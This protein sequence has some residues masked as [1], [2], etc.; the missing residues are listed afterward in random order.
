MSKFRYFLGLVCAVAVFI[1]GMVIDFA[2]GAEK[3]LIAYLLAAT[4]AELVWGHG[5]ALKVSFF[6]LKFT[7]TVFL[8]WWGILFSGILLFVVALL[9]AA[10]IFGFMATLLG[11]AVMV[12]LVLS[13]IFFP[14]HV[15]AHARDLD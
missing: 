11:A 1:F 3:F 6:L 14:I 8:F 2:E 9:I 10:P 5:F 15:I 13:A 7:L 4:V 12:L